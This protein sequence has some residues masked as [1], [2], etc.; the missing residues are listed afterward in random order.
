MKR[1]QRERKPVDKRSAALRRFGISITGFTIAGAFFLGFEDSWAQPVVAVAVAYVL[2][3]VLETIEAF[4]TG[5]RPR[6]LGVGVGGFIDYMLPAHITALSTA[7]LL[8]PNARLMPI[9]F[10]TAAGV[11]SK[12]V[13]RAPIGNGWRHFMNP[14]NFGICMALLLFPWVGISPPYQFTENVYG[15]W[16]WVLPGAILV[17]GTM[18]NGKLTGKLPLIIGWV[19]AFAGQALVRS[20][21]FDT[22]VVAPLMPLTGLV[23]FLYTN[24]MITDPGTT[25]IARRNQ[26]VFGALTAVV[27][28]VLVSFH[29]VF[30]LFFALAIVCA[31]RGLLLYA[32]AVRVRVPARTS[33]LGVARLVR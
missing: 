30:G 21:L 27:Y 25:P 29:V 12:F 10:A 8:Y 1:T 23:F 7:L 13:F 3:L 6:Y 14:S 4:S 5:R 32:V 31:A 26:V 22:A 16:D 15:V 17:A 28:G 9:V 2:E 18:V 19:V 33:E 20:A 24:Y 11:G